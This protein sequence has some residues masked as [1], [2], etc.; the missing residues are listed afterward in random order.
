MATN[1]E[2]TNVKWERAVLTIDLNSAVA[3]VI[4]VE[5][6]A[7]GDYAEVTVRVRV[8]REYADNL[9]AYTAPT[10]SRKTRRS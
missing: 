3:S 5:I 10:K 8:S 7:D 2:S 4:A 9:D 1:L 6:S